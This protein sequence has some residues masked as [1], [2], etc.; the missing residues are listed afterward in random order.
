[1]C[2]FITYNNINT[3]KKAAKLQIQPNKIDDTE[4]DFCR[5]GMCFDPERYV[6][7]VFV[8]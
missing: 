4:L 6:Y 2:S 1:M 8:E 7:R 5:V 3:N